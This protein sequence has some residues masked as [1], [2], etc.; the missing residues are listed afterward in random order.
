MPA[1]A[2]AKHEAVLQAF[3]SDPK[4]IGWRAYKTVY[5]K[6]SQHAAETAWSRLLKIPEFAARLEA[7]KIKVATDVAETLKIS[8]QHVFDELVK[9]GFSNVQDFFDEADR[10]VGVN[11]LTRQ[12]AAAV[13]SLEIETYEEP[14]AGD[15]DQRQ[16]PQ[17]HGGALS[18]AKAKPRQVK[19]IK[20]KLHD[21]R[22][23]LVDLGKHFGLF[24][25][26]AERPPGA[27]ADDAD[28][29][30]PMSDLDA[31]RRVAF[32]LQQAAHANREPAPKKKG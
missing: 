12:Q 21:K 13:S 28:A 17:A 25:P 16:E 18:R 1:L 20:F 15:A 29:R 31:A 19:R 27:G 32:L 10:F 5:R 24:T 9:I 6:S 23:A 8:A 14:G 7:L 26:R 3:L 22:A 4:R 2:N 30:P 11:G